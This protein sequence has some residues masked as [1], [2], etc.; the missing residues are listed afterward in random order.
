M[1]C[2]E[3]SQKYRE[4]KDRLKTIYGECDGLLETF[5]DQAIENAVTILENHDGVDIG[6]PYQSRLL[7]DEDVDKWEA[8]K[9]F[10]TPEDCMAAAEKQKAKKPSEQSCEEKTIFKCDNCGY[11]MKI[12]YSDGQVFGHTPNYCEQ[13]GQKM[14]WSNKL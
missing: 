6:H 7:T 3:E 4:I 5:I 1:R 11:I 8:Y 13:C 2:I 9:S 14:D 12:K 10:G